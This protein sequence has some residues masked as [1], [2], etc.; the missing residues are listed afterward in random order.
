MARHV[1]EMWKPKR[2]RRL[3]GD[4]DSQAVDAKS[5]SDFR[6]SVRSASRC[7]R[8]TH[9]QPL[10]LASTRLQPRQRPQLEHEDPQILVH[11]RLLAGIT[12]GGCGRH[13]RLQ[14]ALNP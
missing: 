5:R 13:L 3:R 7:C 6:L 8:P 12:L 10:A 4:N 1:P 9:R 2:I 11:H 14:R